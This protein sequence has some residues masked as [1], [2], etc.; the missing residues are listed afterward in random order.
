MCRL[1]GYIGSSIQLDNLLYKPEHS[2]VV[3][4]YLPKEMTAGLL[5]ADGFG[6][7]WHHPDKINL[8]YTYKNILPIWSDLNL[9]QITRY[10][11]TKC[12]VGYVRSATPGLFVDLINCQPFTNNNLLFIHN[13]YINNFRKTLYRPIR[14][15]LNDFSYQSIQGNTDSE[16]I[17]A[18][19]LTYL[20]NNPECSVETALNNTLIELT[21]LAYLQQTDFSA[22]IIISTGDRLIASRFSNRDHNP[23][24]YWLRDDPMYPNA[25]IIASEPMFRGNWNN[26]PENS[27]ITVENNLEICINPVFSRSNRQ[28][29]N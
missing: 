15:L 8:P 1:L 29:S 6:I 9:L 10:I 25:V 18:L 14:N 12:F 19:V 22:N 26:C 13:G 17:W 11:E 27:I 24:L 2:L 16:H 7:G 20:Q 28:S 3:Q 4:S 5:N 23:T 21:D